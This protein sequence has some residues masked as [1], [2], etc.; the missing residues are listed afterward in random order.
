MHPGPYNPPPGYAPP[1]PYGRNVPRYGHPGAGSRRG[2]CS[3][4]KVYCCCCCCLFT[5]VLLLI[6]ALVATFFIVDPKTPK[7]TMDGF[8]SKSF[9]INDDGSISS[10]FQVAVKL[11]NPNKH[12]EFIVG[13]TKNPADKAIGIMYQNVQVCSGSIPNFSLTKTSTKTVN[14][15]LNGELKKDSLGDGSSDSLADKLKKDDKIPLL[16]TTMIPIKLKLAGK[17]LFSNVRFVVGVN[18]TMN[19]KNFGEGK[20]LDVSDKKIETA[21]YINKAYHKFSGD[22]FF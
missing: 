6:G 5:T 2:G 15:D 16:L 18:T 12:L 13:E 11:E 7:F 4:M 3:C 21:F 8:E 19:V 10:Q 17:E 1:G 9:K 14:M 22:S 20:K